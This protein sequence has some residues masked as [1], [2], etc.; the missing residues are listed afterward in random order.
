M[1]NLIIQ[2][3]THKLT[4]MIISVCI[5]VPLGAFR[6]ESNVIVKEINKQLC[7]LVSKVKD[8][9]HTKNNLIDFK[10]EFQNNH[11]SIYTDGIYISKN[12]VKAIVRSLPNNLIKN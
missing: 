6:K 9:S 7:S 4:P 2:V 12:G 5:S 11:D 10:A 3:L 8:L 1:I